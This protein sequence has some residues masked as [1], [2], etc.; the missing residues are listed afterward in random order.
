MWPQRNNITELWGLTCAC[1]E[2]LSADVSRPGTMVESHM[3]TQPHV[4]Y[5]NL[6]QEVESLMCKILHV[7]LTRPS[8]CN[9]TEPH[10]WLVLCTAYYSTIKQDVGE[11]N[12]N[13]TRHTT[14]LT[15]V[16][17]TS[18]LMHQNVIAFNRL[19]GCKYQPWPKNC[20]TEYVCIMKI[21]EEEV[22][23]FFSFNFSRLLHAWSNL[24]CC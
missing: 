17:C 22:Q 16:F 20:I 6:N 11:K 18:P 21:S 24:V 1:V 12:S 19:W 23:H 10:W 4:S 14:F 9:V 5:S 2:D 13:Y 3:L 15:C 7:N 8:G